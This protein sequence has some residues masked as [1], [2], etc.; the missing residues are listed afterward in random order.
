MGKIIAYIKKHWWELSATIVAGIFALFVFVIDKKNEQKIYSEEQIKTIKVNYFN[1]IKLSSEI[2]TADMN[3]KNI[4][5]LS[6]SY[7]SE[8]KSFLALPDDSLSYKYIK[9]FYITLIDIKNGRK[10]QNELAFRQRQLVSAV[11]E[12]L[13][14]IKK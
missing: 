7:I 8:Y 1:I 12:Q 5:S 11:N 9:D 3:H 4:D 13:K 6:A 14:N 10:N 2:V